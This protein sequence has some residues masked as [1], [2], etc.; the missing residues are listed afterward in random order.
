MWS[1]F[2]GPFV[3]SGLAVLFFELVYK[4]FLKIYLTKTQIRLNRIS[5]KNVE[6]Y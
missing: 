4:R 3:G 6:L 5:Y 1:T 2:L